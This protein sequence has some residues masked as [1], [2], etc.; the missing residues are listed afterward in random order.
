MGTDAVNSILKAIIQSVFFVI[1]Q[2]L[3]RHVGQISHFEL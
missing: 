2:Y 1:A 3:K